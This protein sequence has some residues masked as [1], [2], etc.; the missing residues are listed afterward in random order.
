MPSKAQHDTTSA[1]QIALD[2]ERLCSFVPPA[3]ILLRVSE[4]S[5]GLLRWRG[6]CLG[7]LTRLLRVPS[8][9]PRRRYLYISVRIPSP[10]NPFTTKLPWACLWSR[11]SVRWGRWISQTRDTWTLLQKTADAPAEG[12]Y[13]NVPAPPQDLLGGEFRVV[14][15]CRMSKTTCQGKVIQRIKPF[16]LDPG[17]KTREPT[18]RSLGQLRRGQREINRRMRR[19][20]TPATT[21]PSNHPSSPPPRPT[22]IPASAHAPQVFGHVN[23]P[24]PAPQSSNPFQP[25]PP[26]TPMLTPPPTAEATM[27]SRRSAGQRRRRQEERQRSSEMPPAQQITQEIMSGS[28]VIVNASRHGLKVHMSDGRLEPICAIARRH[29]R[30]P[31]GRHDLGRMNVRCPDCGALHWGAEKLSTSTLA[32]PKFGI[33]CDSGQVRLP[34]LRPP[35]H[36]LY[37]LFTENMTQAK[38]FRENIWKYNRAFAFTSLQVHEDHS[39]NNGRGPPVFRIFGELCHRGGPLEPRQ[40]QRPTYAQLYIYDPQAAFDNRAQMNADL[41][42]ATLRVLQNVIVRYNKYVQVFEHAWEVMSRQGGQG[43]GGDDVL[44][45]LRP[46]PE[47]PGVHQ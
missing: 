20:P 25:Q 37:K 28:P 34:S 8:G 36:P 39:I 9:T 1:D 7:S 47:Q 38:E 2:A 19:P 44:V 35:P 13:A 40:G 27:L 32:R 46:A 5:P 42:P 3:H 23:A 11:W 18:T 15:F 43:D 12:T 26:Q 29:Y 17:E 33:C 16:G 6:G 21:A 30:E 41:N 24:N 31:A 4:L 22:P 14:A 10:I 45:A